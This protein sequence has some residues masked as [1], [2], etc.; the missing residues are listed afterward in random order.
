MLNLENVDTIVYPQDLNIDNPENIEPT[1]VTTVASSGG[2]HILTPEFAQVDGR[3]GVYKFR[4]IKG[5]D[6]EKFVLIQ[7][8]PNKAKQN[9]ITNTL[10]YLS[11]LF[12]LAVRITQ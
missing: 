3:F 11:E 9:I 12:L 4:I 2:D 6:L 5:L 7:F 1:F 10:L 8:L